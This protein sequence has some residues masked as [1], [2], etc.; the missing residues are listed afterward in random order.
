MD[1][2]LV[3]KPALQALAGQVGAEYLD[4]LAAGGFLGRGDRVPD[5]TGQKGNSWIA[6]RETSP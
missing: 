6:R 1:R 5:V 4:V 2:D 3:D